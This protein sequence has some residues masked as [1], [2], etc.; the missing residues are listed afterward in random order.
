[1]CYLYFNWNRKIN[2]RA[3]EAGRFLRKYL[4]THYT[5]NSTGNIEDIY[6]YHGF[7]QKY[8]SYVTYLINDGSLKI[9]KL[10]WEYI[11]LKP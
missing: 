2:K 1:M 7:L 4:S 10:I 9:D 3:H 8:V 11:L 6:I 5:V